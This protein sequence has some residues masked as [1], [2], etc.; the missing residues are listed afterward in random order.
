MGGGGYAG[1]YPENTLLSVGSMCSRVVT[2]R[3]LVS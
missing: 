3:L 1:G 2:W